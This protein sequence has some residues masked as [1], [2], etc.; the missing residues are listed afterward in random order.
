[1][2]RGGCG[3]GGHQPYDM[4]LF[5][6]C[7]GS[8]PFP[9]TTHILLVHLQTSKV[10]RTQQTSCATEQYVCYLTTGHPHH[11]RPYLVDE[12]DFGSHVYAHTGHSPDGSIHAC[13][14][15]RTDHQA[16]QGE[17]DPSVAHNPSGLR[18]R[19]SE[20]DINLLLEYRNM[21]KSMAAALEWAWLPSSFQPLLP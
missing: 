7:L 14:G 15:V 21:W 20:P 8:T 17:M 12:E 6:S 13:E 10:T 3:R 1:M 4:S 18:D 5:C 2:P 16:R 9:K 19:K 11:T